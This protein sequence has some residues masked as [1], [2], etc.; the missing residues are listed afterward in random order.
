MKRDNKG[1]KPP[2]RRWRLTGGRG[3]PLLIGSKCCAR[4]RRNFLSAFT[5]FLSLKNFKAAALPT[6]AT[7][8]HEL[9]TKANMTNNIHDSVPTFLIFRDKRCFYPLKVGG[10]AVFACKLNIFATDVSTLGH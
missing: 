10:E 5:A 8:D 4:R 1:V 6:G 2:G 3:H 7:R 9:F